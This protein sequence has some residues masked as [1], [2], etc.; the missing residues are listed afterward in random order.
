[1]QTSFTKQEVL[2]AM[3]YNRLGVSNTSNKDEIKDGYFE[4]Y[5]ETSDAERKFLN[6]AKKCLMDD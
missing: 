5:K 4:K 3:Y 1:M 2:D 6:N